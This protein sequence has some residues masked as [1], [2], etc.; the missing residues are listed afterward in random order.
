M[1]TKWVLVPQHLHST[2]LQS[3]TGIQHGAAL[4]AYCLPLIR[5]ERHWAGDVV[6]ETLLCN[7]LG[8]HTLDLDRPTLLPGF[9]TVARLAVEGCR[10][11]RFDRTIGT[12]RRT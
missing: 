6:Q 9:I 7:C 3:I 10:G 1:S 5:R 12:A 4:P 11:A 8:A 2:D